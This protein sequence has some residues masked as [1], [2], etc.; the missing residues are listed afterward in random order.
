MSD[1]K[2]N[3]NG[4]GEAGHIPQYEQPVHFVNTPLPDVIELK[5][6]CQT[7]DR[8]KT[9]LIDGLNLLI[10][11]KPNQG[12]FVCILGT[13]GCGKSTLLRYIS[14]LQTPTCGEVLIHGKKPTK[15]S[16]ISMVFQQYSSFYWYTV[17]HN[18]MLP[19]LL[20]GEKKNIAKE[21]AMEMIKIVGLEGHEKKYAQYPTLSGGQLQRVA[22]ARSLISNPGIL[23]MDEPYGALD[24]NTR[25]EMQLFLSS[26]WEKMQSTIVFVTHDIR[27]AVFLGDDIYI[28]DANPGQIVKSFNVN[29]PLQR[30]RDT[31]REPNFNSL[32]ENIE[33]YFHE[34][35]EMR[36]KSA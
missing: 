24:V 28:M 34:L 21:K 19:L 11:N 4:D 26:L 33:D 27:E 3:K 5:N 25:A 35:Y 15:D 29:L 31:K 6:I 16:P 32:V 23:L 36:K 12:Q 22:I 20:K 2:E 10:E 18:V 30:T 14:A 17:L 7:Y 13:S 1:K 8:G 9:W